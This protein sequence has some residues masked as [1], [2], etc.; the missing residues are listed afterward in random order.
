MHRVGMRWLHRDVSDAFGEWS[1]NHAVAKGKQQG[2]RIMRRVAARMRNRAVVLNWAEWCRNFRNDEVTV[3]KNR[4]S[5]LKMH[6]ETLQSKARASL[7]VNCHHTAP[8]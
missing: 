5:T 8:K 6:L 1:S 7:Q 3:W 4:T 2:E